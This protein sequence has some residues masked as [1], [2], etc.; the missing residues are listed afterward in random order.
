MKVNAQGKAS[1][2]DVVGN[3][4]PVPG[5]YHCRVNHV[6]E[7]LDRFDGVVVWYEVLA[8]RPE[9]GTEDMAGRELRQVMFL[10]EGSPTDEHLRF[11]LSTGILQPG[12]ER[13][14]SFAEAIGREVVIRVSRRKDK[15]TGNEYSGVAERG[16][17]IW[18][19]ANPEVREVPKRAS[20]QAPARAAYKADADWDI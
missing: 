4:P 20:T 1:E 16:L 10:N 19:P 5:W 3:Q 11:A 7:S 8:G 12:E 9:E 18:N 15:K 6:D 14:V 2:S 17:A 13:E